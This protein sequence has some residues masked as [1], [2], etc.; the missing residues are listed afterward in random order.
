MIEL[1][2][3][4]H[5]RHL[6]KMMKYMRYV[7]N[8][9][10]VL[11]CLFLLGGLGFYYSQ[12]LKAL[13]KHF[14]W[15]RP[16][17]VLIWLCL[18]QFGKLAT[19]AE[20]ADQVFLLPKETKMSDY[21]NRALQ[22]S[23][24]LPFVLCALG[25][26]MVMPLVVITTGWRFSSFFLFLVMFV[27]FVISRL[28]LQKYRLYQVSA[29]HY[30]FW[31]SVWFGSSLIVMVLALYVA[32]IIGSLGGL[33][34]MFGLVWFLRKETNAISLDWMA[35][36]RSENQ[37]MRRVYQFIQMFTDVPEISS[38][39]KRRKWLDPIIQNIK[40]IHK[41]TYFYLYARSFL[42]NSEYSG[43]FVRLTAIGTVILFFLQDFWLFLLVA[44]LFLY[45]IGFQLIPIYSQF[46]YMIMTHLYPV[47][48]IQKK[49]AVKRLIA[50]VLSTAAIIFA[51]LAVIRLA[52]IRSSVIVIF[53]L[54]VE[55]LVF[56]KVYVAMRLKNK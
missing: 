24:W 41:N 44:L 12:A 43:L 49:Q 47:N 45:L 11:V 5:A 39:A 28:Y 23:F 27:G 42:R 18:I 10:F 8:D 13:P 1:Y 29:S 19:L 40:P 50:L 48:P 26:G 15:G 53:A 20:A 6:Q 54:A 31:W 30:R 3:K 22:T 38:S 55:I 25:S 36:V 51:L 14:I 16:I 46:D 2:R 9:H 4:R 17:I 32:P 33:I 37:R 56:K 21:L 7:L 52:N 35:M 34:Q